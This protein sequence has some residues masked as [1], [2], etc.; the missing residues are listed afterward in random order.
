MVQQLRKSITGLIFFLISAA[1]LAQPT[2]P[3]TGP[4][5][6]KPDAP[7]RYPSAAALLEDL[8]RAGYDLPDGADAWERLLKH[9]REN[10][11]E[12]VAWRKSA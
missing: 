12:G 2:G 5:V 9:A 8:E 6:L 10:A 7:D 3:S 4:L 1:A 11:T